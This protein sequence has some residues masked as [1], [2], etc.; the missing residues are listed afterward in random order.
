MIKGFHNS[1]LKTI[2]VVQLAVFTV[3]TG[4]SIKVS[5]EDSVKVGIFQNKP[6]VYFEN[7]PKGLFVEVLDYVA[8]KEGWNIEYVVCDL[9]ECIEL[10]NANELDLMTSLGKNRERLKTLAYSE[11]PIWTFWGTVYAHSLEIQNLFDLRDKRIGVRSNSK[12]TIGFKK[13]IGGFE[14]PVQYVEFD[15]YEP[16]FEALHTKSIDAVVVN[17]T[18]AF[19]EQ[20]VSDTCPTSIVFNPFSAYFVALQNG[21]HLEKLTIIDEHVRL[22]KADK[23]SLFYSFQQKLTGSLPGYWTG[24]KIG[25]AAAIL[26]SGIVIL[27]A[28]WRYRSLVGVNRK[29]VQSIADR[30]KTEKQ[31]KQ[32][33]ER[34]RRMVKNAADAIFLFDEKGEFELVN[35]QACKS[36]GYTEDEL[37]QLSVADIAPELTQEEVLAINTGTF[38]DQWPLTMT[39]T[40]KRKDGSIFP[41]EVSTDKIEIEGEPRFVALARDISERNKIEEVTQKQAV[42]GQI[43]ENALNEIYIF[44]VDTLLFTLVNKGARENIGYT[45]AELQELT[46]ADIRLGVTLEKFAE[47]IQPLKEDEVE[48]LVFETWHQRKD[49]SKYPVEVHLQKT[50]TPGRQVFIAVIIDIS[51]R[52][53][54][55]AERRRL[56]AA[57]EQTSETI[58]ITDRNGTIQYVNPAF[59][60]LTGYSREE[61][62]GNTPRVLKSGKHDKLFY[63]K[64]W[65]SLLQGNVWKGNL[66]NRKKDGSLFEEDATISPMQDSHGRITNFVAVKRDVTR[67]I[68]LEKQLRQAMKM[69]AIGTLAGGIAH[70][71][72]NIL[73][74]ILGYGEMAR[75]QVDENDQLKSDIDQVIR[76][77]N[78]AKQ[79]V[80]QILTFSRQGEEDF[81]PIEIQ[82]IVKEA[83]KLL[84]SSLPST[85]EMQEHID[86]ECRPV[87]ADSTQIHQVLLN[88]CTNAKHAMEKDGGTLTVSLSEVKVTALGSIPACPQL[89]IGIYLDLSIGDTGCGMDALTQSKIFDPFFT[90]KEIGKGTGLGLA[91]VHGIIKQHNGEMSVESKPGEGTVFHLY[92]PVVEKETQVESDSGK[93]VQ[94]GSERIL[95]VDDEAEVVVMLQRMLEILGY[96][97]TSFASSVDALNAF[98]AAPDDFDLLLTDMT[99]PEMTGKALTKEILAIRP[100]FPVILCTGFSESIDEDKAKALGVREYILKPI[101]RNQLAATV[102]KVFDNG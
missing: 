82:P 84:R 92:L 49:G 46:P 90:T 23:G 26:F 77:G 89:E 59:E 73:A 43:V 86:L 52:N 48:M 81:S 44:E 102:R 88:C 31:L 53:E 28:F 38:S 71:F 67:E 80:K 91:V 50:V 62:I 100:D 8:E 79:L 33:E 39:G 64:M 20:K 17:N 34:F 76:A 83:L 9:K 40:Q 12:I 24:K 97:V 3:L 22:L 55:E 25:I 21:S 45:L 54:L 75:E 85:I 2:C 4:M 66:I 98:K 70:D 7:G 47:T 15:N 14:I 11:E 57:I 56:A 69:E 37:L 36:L 96:T 93:N 27:M 72:N 78:R 60:T 29:L 94:Y 32:S 18:Y 65:T 95:V 87:L 58:V 61:A 41:V 19:E 30:K 13:L 74:A 1:F 6:V 68:S 10:I 35:E 42:F 5:A 51:R 101:L 63:E 16:A 99:M